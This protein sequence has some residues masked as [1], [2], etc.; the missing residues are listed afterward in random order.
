MPQPASEWLASGLAPMAAALEGSP[1]LA[2]AAQ[3][4]SLV[5]EG[6]SVCNLTIGDFEPA[7]YPLPKQL[8]EGT[9]QAMRDGW[10]NYPPSTGIPELRTA[11]QSVCERR[12]GWRPELDGILVA[13]GARPVLYTCYL[14]LVQ[15][16]DKVV[17][18]TP[19][20]NNN[21]YAHMVGARAVELPVGPED[22]FFPSFAHIAP[23]LG[24]ARLILLNSPLNPSGTCID[25]AA[26]LQLCQAIVAE[27]ERRKSAKQRPLFLCYDQI[28]WMLTFGQTRH[29]DPVGVL[30]A[31]VDY[32]I[33]VDGISKC[34]AATGLR[35]GWT[36]APPL[37]ADAMNKLLGHIGAW[38]PKAEQRAA[39][40][41]LRD[42]D[43]IDSYL[44]F[45]RTAA[46]ERLTML[47]QRL[48]AMAGRGYPL[49]ALVPQGAIYLSAE[50]ALVGWRDGDRVLANAEQ[51]HAWLLNEVGIATVPFDV[52]GAEH[53]EHWHR[54]SVGAVGVPEL[55]AG[56]DRLDAALGRLQPA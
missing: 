55:S 21:H 54:L 38:A 50:F 1:I 32:T 40:Q 43:A 24:D 12:L 22:N 10:T 36:I 35:V 45:I 9:A 15:P 33:Y 30:P 27:N 52:F 14:A 7:H 2:I 13:G 53:A 4:R 39:S 41:L 29:V 46:G 5:A 34:F 19:S 8:L 28:Y 17:Y 51:V 56:L 3:V 23:H 11:V 47:H 18:A 25:R 42:D 6:K 31:M 44:Q 49:R 16:G 20:W 26:L 48:T 37:V